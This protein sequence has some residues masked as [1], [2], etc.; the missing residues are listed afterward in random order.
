[1]D[2]RIGGR[3]RIGVQFS[4]SGQLSIATGVYRQIQPPEKLV[5]TWSWDYDPTLETLLTL[6]FIEVAGQT[7]LVLTHE[8]FST[9]ELRDRHNQG[10]TACLDALKRVLE[11]TPQI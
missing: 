10:W 2:L 3:F 8:K 9:E 11:D 5:F 7:E 1:M 6:E 4:N